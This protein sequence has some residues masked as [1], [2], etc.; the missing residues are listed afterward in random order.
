MLGGVIERRPWTIIAAWIILVLILA[1]YAAR[2]D[3]V[4]KTE[5]RSFLPESVESARAEKE[6]QRIINETG[7]RPF[8]GD[9]LILVHGVN[10]SL[11]TY[12][13]LRGPYMEAKR[14]APGDVFSWVD[15]VH[16]VEENIS[17]GAGE[18]L[19][20]SLA[21]VE[22]LLRLNKGYVDTLN[23]TNRTLRLVLAADEA[24]RGVL[25]AAERLARNS[26]ALRGAARLELAAC[27]KFLPA[28][29]MTYYDVVRAEALLEELT[30]AYENGSLSS[31]DVA[32]VVAASNLTQY[33]VEPLTPGLVALVYNYTMSAGG[34]QAFNNTLAARLAA[35]LA[36]RAVEESLGG[37]ASSAKPVFDA[38]AGLW[39]ENV[40]KAPD[41]RLLVLGAPSPA[42][43]Q[44]LL[45][46]D[47]AGRIEALKPGAAEAA[48][49]ALAQASPGAAPILRDTA[50]RLAGANCSESALGEALLGAV[51]D[52]LSAGLQGAP[53]RDVEALAR[54]ALNGSVAWQAALDA[55][56][57]M[58]VA[59]AGIEQ[60][61]RLVP[62]LEQVIAVLDPQGRG[63]EPWQAAAAAAAV[64][65]AGAGA[66][67]RLSTLLAAARNSTSPVQAAALE[68]YK[69]ILAR[70][71]GNESL[72]LLRLLAESGLLGASNSTLLER[73]PE[74][75]APMVAERGNISEEQARLI[76]AHAA[77][78]AS[79]AE[80]RE[81]AVENITRTMLRKAWPRIVEGLRGL[82]VE[83]DL[84]GFV[85]AYTPASGSSALDGFNETTSLLDEALRRAGLSGYQLVR[86]GSKYM[87]HEMREA[88]KRDIER[89]D[90]TSMILVIVIM[91]IVL[92]SVAAVF[93]PFI[94][95]GFGLAASLAAA[96]LL[97]RAGVIDVTTHSRT[98]MYTTGLGLGI[99][100]AVYVSKRFREAA[101]RGLDSRR[102]AR[103]A[104]ER[105]WRPVVAG[106]TTAMIGFGSML[107]ARGFPFL[108]SI[109]S[110]VPLTILAVMVAS[111]TFIPALLAYVGE[112]RWFWWPR[113]PVERG[114]GPGRLSRAL[115]RLAAGRVGAVLLLAFVLLGAAGYVVTA[116]YPGSYDIT[117]NLPRD[118]E[119][120]RAIQ[121]IHEYY[122]PGV[123]YPAYVVASSPD[124]AR[125]IAASLANLSC[126][127]RTIVP[128]SLGGRVVYA[129]MSVDPLSREGVDCA[130]EIRSAA[131][132][133][134]PESLVGGMSAVNLDLYEEIT[135]VFYHRVYP[136]AVTL[137]FL[138]MLA[139]YGGLATAVAAILS[140]A[141]GAYLGSA[142]A[143]LVYDRILG[144]PVLWYLPVITFTAILGVGM[145][146]NSFYIA[147]A[148][149]E[150]EK[151]C[152]VDAVR[153][154]VALSAPVVLGLATIM[155]SAYLGLAVTKTPGLSEMGTA[156]LL[157]VLLAGLGATLM[158]TP[159][160]IALLG[161]RAWWPR[162]PRGAAGEG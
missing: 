8:S 87:E 57:R 154:S 109:G 103:E 34:P 91:G 66:Q 5:T 70:R 23:A 6:L 52:A 133:I 116:R 120:Y 58:V 162:P 40:S 100:Y 26:T 150:C 24:Y 16:G 106:A 10:V 117:L 83:K 157:G 137:M 81:S 158:L 45:L 32:R 76:L 78:V 48:A 119:S 67:V 115:G 15:V 156:L 105:G 134:D 112:K 97:A 49:E 46:Q 141:L 128:D 63:L 152:S 71:G 136:A 51:E 35:Q 2:I 123:L 148:R 3:S 38:V 80:D 36:W 60:G 53:E 86:G 135:S 126:V 30:G 33:G 129:Y 142:L 94:G 96:Y 54:A 161:R 11:D 12:Y 155:A 104:F 50:E 145:D 41:H 59:R 107:L 111:I 159:P 74:L 93:L 44:L 98:I 61:D 65:A 43:G 118:T 84:Q 131:H 101:A 138:T 151:K 82:M 95:I 122:E 72:A 4:V 92:E 113:H 7:S 69:A 147:R 25:A 73:A 9:Y 85:V 160:L 89:S 153:E 37:N 114:H 127:S 149:E 132:R 21:A 27:S 110:N 18:G 75:L 47:V 99:D 121:M 62:V 146:Y 79:G 28:V 130:R 77:L 90:R 140:V 22:G 20:R 68:A 1:P 29:A 19:N 108:E 39:L 124:R 31:S 42:Q 88:A 56:V 13:R 55:A 125:E 14:A 139:A 17:R 144:T 143:I 102:A 64:V